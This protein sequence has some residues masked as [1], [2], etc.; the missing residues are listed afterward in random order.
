LLERVLFYQVS[1]QAI[2]HIFEDGAVSI[3]EA[4]VSATRG[5]I[6]MAFW[7]RASL[8]AGM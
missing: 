6:V 2:P 4:A 1:A 3:Q 7:L 5:Q 8:G